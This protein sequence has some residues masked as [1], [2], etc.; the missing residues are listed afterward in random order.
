MIEGLYINCKACG[1]P[2]EWTNQDPRSSVTR[3]AVNDGWLVT[4]RKKDYWICSP[5]RRGSN[6]KT[7][8]SVGEGKEYS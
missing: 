4:D 2:G 8:Q 7:N 5:C 1:K 6:D 3:M